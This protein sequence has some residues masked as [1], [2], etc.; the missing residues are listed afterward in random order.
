[1]GIREALGFMKSTKD[2]AERRKADRRQPPT[3]RRTDVARAVSG[4]RR[5][6]ENRGEVDAMADALEDI[7]RWEKTSERSLKVAAKV[8]AGDKPSN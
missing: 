5:L 8:I 1:M 6:V 7:L 4:D 3:E 2:N